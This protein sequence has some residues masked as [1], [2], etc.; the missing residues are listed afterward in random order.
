MNRLALICER[1]VIL[2]MAMLFMSTS[3]IA[4][5]AC[6]PQLD[7]LEPKISKLTDDSVK[8]EVQ[9]H[10]DAARKAAGNYDEDG[11][12]EHLELAMKALGE[13]KG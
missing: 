10:Y 1:S 6:D 8:A 5:G 12:L 7:K 3:A 11:C 2:A 9:K 13:E 4:G